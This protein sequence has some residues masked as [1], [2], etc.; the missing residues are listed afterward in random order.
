MGK[1]HRK[2]AA[3]AV[4]AVT[5]AGVIVGGAFSSPE[6]LLSDGPDTV[7][8]TVVMNTGAE[9]DSDDGDGSGEE[10]L[11]DENEDRRF[12]SSVRK[13]ISRTPI[14]FRAAVIL[15]LWLL[16]TFM[17]GMMSFFWSSFLSPSLSSVL[18]WIGIALVGAAV[19][20]LS[21][22]TV[23]PD[24]PI[25]KLLNRRTILILV[26]VCLVFGI[27]DSV[28]PFFWDEYDSLSKA[29]K[30][31]GSFLC[32]SVPLVLLLCRHKKSESVASADLSSEAFEPTMEEK[33]LA[34]RKLVTEL[35]DSVCRK[36]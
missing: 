22:K 36:L 31:S 30:A 29:L 1:K 26:M 2:A 20:L 12:F 17:T 32:S 23:F 35:A 8:Q 34:A 18:N 3:S 14:G 7:V 13:L 16:G 21:A 27:I 25:R 19:F 6:E 24:L 33:E 5:A 28:L 4:A 11:E 10:D 9:I 15:P